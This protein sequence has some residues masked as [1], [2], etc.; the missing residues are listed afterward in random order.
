[1]GS[2]TPLATRRP[3]VGW[4]FGWTALVVVA[5]IVGSALGLAALAVIPG[6]DLDRETI[7]GA[8]GFGGYVELSLILLGN[9][10]VRGAC[11]GLMLGA[12]APVLVRDRLPRMP[13]VAI[14]GALLFA[15]SQAIGSLAWP[16]ATAPLI[17]WE[18]LT[19][20]KL[21]RGAFVVVGGGA[22]A[23]ASA[24]AF[25][26]LSAVPLADRLP[27][28]RWWFAGVSI[29]LFVGGLPVVITLAI[30]AEASVVGASS[31]L[32]APLIAGAVSGI[33]A[34]LA[35]TERRP[36]AVGPR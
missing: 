25:A 13:V 9:A 7:D 17:L 31:L 26:G 28:L 14:A 23:L 5:W 2:A 22:A 29:G 24:V 10:A 15:V 6:S 16:L 1:M 30:D 18:V 8:S 35:L 19:D 33:G 11:I 21:N 4:L 20:G 27:Q 12:V 32:A 36:E 3:G 34:R